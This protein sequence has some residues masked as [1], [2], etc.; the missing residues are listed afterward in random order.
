MLELRLSFGAFTESCAAEMHQNSLTLNSSL[1]VKTL[2]HA[3]PVR[4]EGPTSEAHPSFKSIQEY[5]TF[6]PQSSFPAGTFAIPEAC[7][8]ATPT[9]LR[10]D[11][12]S[13]FFHNIKRQLMK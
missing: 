8:T 5:L 1:F 10:L 9:E 2:F 4:L 6:K 13:R 3:E 7:K 11:S 12:G